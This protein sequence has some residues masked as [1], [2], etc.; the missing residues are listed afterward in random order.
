MKPILI[1]YKHLLPAST[2]KNSWRAF[3]ILVIGL[4]LTGMATFYA[5]RKV[6]SDAKQEFALNCN[7]IKI[8]TAN[9]L[10]ACAQ[11]LQTASAFF[12]ASD[13]VTREQWKIFNQNA[14]YEKILPGI[15]GLGY[16]LLVTKDQLK[17]HIK[18]IRQEGFPNYKIW[19]EGEGK[20]Y[21]PVI[22][23]EPFAGRNLNVP[24]YN[25][26]SDST[27]RKAMEIAR[28]SDFAT[29]SGKVILV[30]NE[31]NDLQSGIVMFVPVYH[32][33]M[34]LHTVEQRRAAI[35]G[36][37]YS[38]YHLND[39]MLGILG[40]WDLEKPNR[41]RLQIYED[42]ISNSSLIYDS[43]RNDVEIRK[44]PNSKTLALQIKPFEKKWILQFSQSDP[45]YFYFQK[46]V[47]IVFVTGIFIS[48]LLFLL[49]FSL[50]NTRGNA[51][52]IASVLTA[53]L[54]EREHRIR[55][56]LENSLDASYKRNLLTHSYEYLSPAYS[57]ISGYSADQM[58]TMP[59]ETIIELM[60]PD[61]VPEVNRIIAL[62]LAE[63][64]ITTYQL[65]YRFRHKEGSY[66]W[67][68]DKY[69][70]LRNLKGEPEAL[71]GSVSDIS[72][73]K[74]IEEALSNER[75]LLR[76]LIDNIPDS[77]YCMDLECRKTLANIT[78]LRY[79][80]AATEA[81]VLGKNDYDFYP[82]ELAEEFIRIDRMVMQS[83]EPLLNCEEYLFDEKGGKKWLL[84]SKIPL[85]NEEGKVTG[86]LGIG[87]DITDRKLAEEAQRESESLYRSLF[88]N[89]LNG[90]AYC[91]M[92]FDDDKPIDFIYLSVN[93]AFETQT[94]LENVIG[95]RVS[96]VIPGIQESDQQLLELYG[97]V[98]LTGKAEQ[99]EFFFEALQMWLSI[100]V[101]CP[102]HGHF[103]V[104]FDVITDRKQA[105][106]LI[107]D[108]NVQLQ[109]L[110]ASKDKLFSIIA[111]DLR[112]PFNGFLGLTQI[113]AEDLSALTRDEIREMAES[114]RNSAATLYRLLE[115]LLQWSTLQQ[116]RMVFNPVSIPLNGILT[117]SIAIA[118]LSAN[119]KEIEIECQIPYIL[120]VYADVKMVQTILRNLISNAIKFTNKGGKITIATRPIDELTTEISIN[121]SGIGMSQTI[122]NGLFQM[123]INTSRKGT[124]GETSTGL[125]LLICSDF[126][127]KNGGKL[128]VESKVGIGST[129][130]FTLPNKLSL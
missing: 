129:F 29:L 103:V 123:D 17:Q 109:S 43:Q 23:L 53:E 73:R 39:L 104:V 69:T 125:G 11:L 32:K 76:T 9:R 86:L 12:A 84:S 79:M 5:Q 128:R 34:A 78:D 105:E 57:R 118:K 28:D 1:K 27:R 91:R 77:I 89:M 55:E 99:F 115:N 70:V 13:T 38:P 30:Q 112:S 62:S 45:H 54:K 122:I 107:R 22:Y 36:W 46:L 26:F 51:Q 101:Y 14:K 7:E 25:G 10:R 21:T 37:I 126:I 24:G 15:Q 96:E 48:L 20:I 16:T 56:V 113:M 19:P 2:F 47:T 90:F 120:E 114:M 80:G 95:K 124:E 116:G 121:D 44:Y 41:I 85:R 82:Q 71:I 42:Q 4:G 87:R 88:E 117:E 68:H 127:E 40:H 102:L 64:S 111:H 83:G 61:D 33:G 31:E 72:D 93:N 97:R 67:F 94:G 18:K 63:T 92:I 75:F 59:I 81:E 130:Y 65:E 74:M 106:E 8:K 119:M 3:F 108:K 98:S 60:H 52:R 66:R 35:K 49:S 110:N 100:S 6:E 50:F 58:R